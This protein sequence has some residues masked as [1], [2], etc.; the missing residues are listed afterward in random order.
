VKAQGRQERALSIGLY[1][2]HSQAL[3]DVSVCT[4]QGGGGKCRCVMLA[5]V[6]CCQSRAAPATPALCFAWLTYAGLR[7]VRFILVPRLP[8]GNGNVGAP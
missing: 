5:S 3:V 1:F 8:I 6:L 7:I 4:P 2:V